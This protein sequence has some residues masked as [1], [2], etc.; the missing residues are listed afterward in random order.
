MDEFPYTYLKLPEKCRLDKPV[1]KK[2]F[3]ENAKFSV[4][5]K[6][7]FTKDINHIRWK[8]SIKP[9]VTLIFPVKEE[10][11]HY[12]EIAVIEVDL[13]NDH[14]VNRLT[15][16]IH[17]A[18]P[19]PMMIVF[20]GKQWVRL[21]V[22]DKRFNLADNQAATIEEY[23]VTEQIDENLKANSDRA[24]VE[25]LAYDKQP[26]LNL[27]VFYKGWIDAFTAYK[28]ASVTGNFEMLDEQSKKQQRIKALNEH[29]DLEEQ[30]EALKVKL[31]KEEAFNEKVKLNVDI[32][33]LEKQ[34]KQIA[35][36]L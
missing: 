23:W 27:K 15:D 30:I 36:Q 9:T 28:V 17:R 6:K 32:K 13:E 14:H 10:H 24:F 20:K 4:T 19:Y 16:I 12:D 7:W 11:F 8:Y 3:Y 25:Q 18:I 35:K 29:R 1:Y 31:K 22:A 33:E 21:S 34:L 26:R 5:D 2:L